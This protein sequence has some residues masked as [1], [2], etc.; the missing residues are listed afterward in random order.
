MLRKTDQIGVQFLGQ[1]NAEN[2]MSCVCFSHAHVSLSELK[3]ILRVGHPRSLLI[4]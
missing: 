4:S 1:N 2:L 3:T